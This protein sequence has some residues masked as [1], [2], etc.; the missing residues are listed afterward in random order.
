MS[1][2]TDYSIV[3]PVFNSEKTLPD[4]YKRLTEQFGRISDQ[5]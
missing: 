1:E 2:K 4:L 5:L 3:I